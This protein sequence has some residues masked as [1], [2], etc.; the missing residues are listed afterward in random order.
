MVATAAGAAALP[1]AGLLRVETARAQDMPHLSLDDPT[2]KAL[3]YVEQSSTEGQWC[4]NCQFWQGGD[5]EWGAC[6]LFPGK[7]VARDGWCKSWT[8]KT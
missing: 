5:A 8:K 6:P 7:A 3:A 4:H 1:L 2:A